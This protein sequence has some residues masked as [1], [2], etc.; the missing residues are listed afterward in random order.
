MSASLHRR[1]EVGL[2]SPRTVHGK[3]FLPLVEY[4]VY[5]FPLAAEIV[6]FGAAQPLGIV[7]V[8]KELDHVKAGILPTSG[9]LVADSISWDEILEKALARMTSQG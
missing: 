7:V 9:L 8:W 2:A 3:R 4:T 1:Q 5:S 6:T